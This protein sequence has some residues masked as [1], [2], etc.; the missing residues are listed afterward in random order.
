VAHTKSPGTKGEEEGSPGFTARIRHL[1][2]SGANPHS[3]MGIVATVLFLAG[4]AMMVLS[5]L[6]HLHLWM[7]GYR[8]IPTT[9]PLFLHTLGPLF[10]A[11]T[12]TGIAL[13]LVLALFRRVWAAVLSFGF[14]A[15]TMVGF[16][17]SVGGG[18]YGFQDSWSAPFAHEAFFVELIALI[19]IAA[20]AV[21]CCLRRAPGGLV[22]PPTD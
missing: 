17:I 14:V 18:L 12:V 4:A 15:L 22:G 3:A 10:M 1:L 6:I 8:Q 11:Q 16:L 13:A 5:A 7:H 19:T 20:G 9:G 21:L 2:G